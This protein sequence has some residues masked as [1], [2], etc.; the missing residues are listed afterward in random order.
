MKQFDSVPIKVPAK[1]VFN[2]SHD[3]KSS[4]NFDKIYPFMCKQVYPGDRFNCKA[5]VFMRT[6]PLFAP[7]LHNVDMYIYFVYVP[8]RL[9]W[10]ENKK[11]DFRVFITGGE[12]G[13]QHPVLP[14][15]TYSQLR[16]ISENATD[17]GFP[18]GETSF[19]NEGSLIDHLGLPSIPK[20]HLV[21]PSSGATLAISSLPL[22][23][24]QF[25]W[26]ELFRNQNLQN[27][28][29][30]SY[31]QGQESL[32]DLAKLVTIRKKCWEKDYF[33]ACLPWQQRGAAAAIPMDTS[34]AAISAVVETQKLYVSGPFAGTYIESTD[35]NQSSQMSTAT[36]GALCATEQSM[37]NK[38]HVKVVDY[39]QHYI[40]AADIARQLKVTGLQ[41]GTINDLRTMIRLQAWLENNA[42]CGSRYIEQLLAH[43]GVHSSDARLQ[44]PELLGGGK[45]PLIFSEIPQ[46]SEDTETSVQGNLA[47]KGEL[48][49]KTEGF[50]EYFEEHGFL[51]GLLSIIPRTSYCQGIPR[52]FTYHEKTDFYF[53]E[54]ANLSEQAVSKFEVYYDPA[55]PSSD[56]LGEFGYIGRY[57]E[58][59]Y[60][61]SSVHGELRTNLQQWHLGRI[62]DSTPSL[63]AD[64]VEAQTRCNIF[65][66]E[67]IAN[68]THDP[69]ICQIHLDIRA[70]RPLPEFSVPSICATY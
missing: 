12:D 47:G 46:T 23:A 64:F 13:Q 1:N 6:Q 50:N 37:F 33:T 52:E 19:F 57:D 26:N 59:R 39:N 56:A 63:N 7:V 16:Q 14:Y 66:I 51:F 15:W 3:V 20:D 18:I 29:E 49:G 17:Y 44:R 38:S 35:G 54:F 42:R 10:N 8:T 62:F 53:P 31:D 41:M 9:T 25:I 21:L 32:S 27:E 58:M 11:S 45:I 65:S 34:N 55:S 60:I 43:F 68:G 40:T 67:D 30:F 2:L 4:Y 61:P 28:I 5:E 48:Y 69:F 22:R 70:E 24:Y 36:D